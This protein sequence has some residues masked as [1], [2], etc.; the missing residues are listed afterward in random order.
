M[1]RRDSLKALTVGTLTAG[2][3]ITGGCNT[4]DEE[5]AAGI[6]ENDENKYGRT[7]E[8]K[9]Y[10]AKLMA[11]KYFT[12]DEM[13]TIAILTDIIIPKDERSGSASEAKV[14]D[15]IEF[16]VKDQP[17]YKVPVR[18]GMRWLNIESQKRFGNTFAKCTDKQRIELVDMIAYPQKAAPEMAP[19]VSFF[20][21]MRNLTATGF[22]TSQ[23]GI[24]DLDYKGNTPN[25]WDGVPEDVLKQ[26]G[27]EYDA[28]TL[29]QCIKKEDRG[30]MMTWDS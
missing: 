9:E 4:K 3:I 10:D 7:A 29:E 20:N 5:K 16:I 28:K 1:D 18:G 30:K 21:T 2:T 26:Y 8:E 23:M 24:K 15:F 27:F 25:E 14:P 17:N 19:G 11:E 12:D 22:F 6:Q 13:A